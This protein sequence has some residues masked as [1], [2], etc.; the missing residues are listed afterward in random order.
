MISHYDWAGGREAMLR[1]GPAGAPVVVAALPL[2]EEANRTRALVVTILRALAAQGIGAALPD[3]PG[4]GESLVPVEAVTL[5]DWRAA[6]AASVTMLGD[7]S[8]PVHAISVRGGALVET[9]APVRS[10]WQL[11]PA[12]GESVVREL[13]RARA[14]AEPGT[15]LDFDPTAPAPA[16]PPIEIAGNQ[17]PRKLLADLA[18]AMPPIGARI[19]VVRLGRDRG[20]FDRKID[21][22]SPWRRAEPENDATLAEQLTDDIALWVRS[23]AG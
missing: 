9:E 14:I 11:G 8:G 23:C 1:F 7:E 18:A 21:V 12:T 3:L 13:L 22:P 16:G 17:V 15:S 2:F 4:T 19:R 20:V 6:F 5:A 10:R